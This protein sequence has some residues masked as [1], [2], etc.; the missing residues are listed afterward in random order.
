LGLPDAPP[1]QLLAASVYTG[2]SVEVRNHHCHERDGC[3]LT[4][5]TSHPAPCIQVPNLTSLR[6][7]FVD[8]EAANCRLGL[9]ML[10][11]AGVTKDNIVFLSNGLCSDKLA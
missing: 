8:D 2:A 1:N 4:D 5:Y 7:V 6:V 10:T 9:R 3:A 11:K